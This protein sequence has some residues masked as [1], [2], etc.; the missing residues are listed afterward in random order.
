MK[1]S[2]VVPEYSYGLRAPLRTVSNVVMLPSHG[3]RSSAAEQKAARVLTA[4]QM[5]NGAVLV[6]WHAAVAPSVRRDRSVFR[7]EA[8]FNRFVLGASDRATVDSLLQDA[9]D[10]V[11]QTL[12]LGTASGGVGTIPRPRVPGGGDPAADDGGDGDIE[13]SGLGG[14]VEPINQGGQNGGGG[15]TNLPGRGRF[16]SGGGGGDPAADDDGGSDGSDDTL[17]QQASND[18]GSGQGP[19]DSGS[20]DPSS[21]DGSVNGAGGVGDGGEG[22][23]LP[24][25]VNLDGT[26]FAPDLPSSGDNA[27][28]QGQ[29]E[30]GLEVLAGVMGVI[31]L[32]ASAPE[33]ATVA[34]TIAAA[35]ATTLGIIHGIGKDPNPDG[36]DTSGGGSTTHISGILGIGPRSYNISGETDDDGTSGWAMATPSSTHSGSSPEANSSFAAIQ[37]TVSLRSGDGSDGWVSVSGMSTLAQHQLQGARELATA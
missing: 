18:S 22:E 23:S 5:V 17:T 4:T 12:G 3:K 29:F 15:G 7:S 21:N 28:L 1:F 8:A 25:G 31:A 33:D 6:A 9:Q 26:T 14:Y 32:T 10:S 11:A 34:G 13:V 2:D 37:G 36:D 27:N 30:A 19:T 35:A 24:G 20:N 16:G